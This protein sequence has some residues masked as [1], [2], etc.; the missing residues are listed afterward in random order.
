MLTTRWYENIFDEYIIYVPCFQVYLVAGGQNTL[1]AS[2]EL[3]VQGAAG[4]TEA[5]PLPHKMY[6][7]RTVSINNAVIATGQP[8]MFF[9]HLDTILSFLCIAGGYNYKTGVTYDTILKFDA[10]G[11]V[12]SE[13]GRMR[14]PRTMHG[15]SV[16]RLQ[17]IKQYC[18]QG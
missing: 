4:W 10:I 14:Q 11:L 5:G 16:A 2:T 6:G 15:A 8:S 12:W 3:L 1:T 9:F 7:L 13:V 18:Q 17:D